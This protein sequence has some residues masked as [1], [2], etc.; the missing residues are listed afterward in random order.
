MSPTVPPETLPRETA[1]LAAAVQLLEEESVHRMCT[2]PERATVVGHATIV[3]VTA[4]L[5]RQCLPEVGE[6]LHI[7][8]LTEP[9]VDLH[10]R[11]AQSLLRGLALEPDLAGPAPSPV[12][13]KAQE[14]EGQRALA[15]PQ[16]LAGVILPT[17]EQTGLVGVE[18][19][20]EFPQP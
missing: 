2:T 19:Q 11:T 16:R 15:M 12:V 6:G 10:Q 4:H 17:P 18:A 14:I 20:P 5:A 7:A 9:T 8:C 1:P 3:E 13:G